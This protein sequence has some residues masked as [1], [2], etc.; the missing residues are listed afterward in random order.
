MGSKII[1]GK[2]VV[3]NLD[4]TVP[5][6][7]DAAI[8]IENDRIVEV[9][10]W[11]KVS[12]R[13][14]S[15]EVIGSDRHGVLPGFVNAHHH[16]NGIPLT[17]QGILDNVLEPWILDLKASRPQRD[18]LRTLYSAARLLRTGV[19]SVIDLT[20]CSGARP[21]AERGQ[22]AR[23]DAYEKSGLRA[24]VAPGAT[25][26]SFLVHGRGE[27]ENFL[28]SLP[29]ALSQRVQQHLP[30]RQELASADYLDLICELHREYRNHPRLDVWFGPPGPQWVGLE[31]FA[32]IAERARQEDIGIQTHAVES[33]YEKLDGIRAY[34]TSTIQKLYE[35]DVL[36]ERCSLA[37]GVW[38]T[39][40]DIAILAET[41]CAISHNPS[42]NLRLRAGVAS[43]NAIVAAGVTL[44]LGMDGTTINDNED[45]FDEMRLA[46]R[47]H[48]STQRH[49]AA[50]STREIYQLA[51]VGGAKLLG[52]ETEIG[53]IATGFKADLIL[54]DLDRI[55]KPWLAPKADPLDVIVLRAR[56]DDVDTVIIDG[57]I[58][59]A[60]GEPLGFKSDE[61]TNELGR[62]LDGTPTHPELCEL[63]ADLGPHLCI[64]ANSLSLKPFIPLNIVSSRR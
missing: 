35:V 64:T 46:L 7:T 33:F 43:L 39:D 17:L 6:E 53:R 23:L 59:L 27:D 18:D 32:K 1:R 16:S 37:H 5:I 52:R 25:Y 19:T 26:E 49:E 20:Q 13:Y 22:R 47:L 58:V 4:E 41:G 30:L 60:K 14:P 24:I 11:S 50:P 62:D 9:G 48:R 8:V 36:S 55:S 31:L 40:A 29:I 3:T 42:S 56:A 10:S 28:A 44:G 63:V 61:V 12:L 15:C 54:L 38:V 34:G 21:A 2:Y 45:M 57:E 51:T